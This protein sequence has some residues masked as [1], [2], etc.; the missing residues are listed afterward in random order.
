M[1]ASKSQLAQ[2]MVSAWAIAKT[3]SL[4]FGGS[5]KQYLSGALK[6]AWKID[7]LKSSVFAQ[8]NSVLKAFFTTCMI[9]VKA[10]A[11]TGDASNNEAITA[12][13]S[14]IIDDG[15][16]AAVLLGNEKTYQ[17][18]KLSLERIER[19][20]IGLRLHIDSMKNSVQILKMARELI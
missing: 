17:T 8:Q 16:M 5:S 1:K 13:F 14:Q 19:N 6:A 12:Q 9:R 7:N 11:E 20:P 18:I 10:R 15:E 4:K 2:I 3:A